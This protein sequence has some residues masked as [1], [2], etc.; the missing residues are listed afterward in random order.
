MIVNSAVL[1]DH[2]RKDTIAGLCEGRYLFLV[3]GI[4]LAQRQA[5]SICVKAGK[6]L[7]GLFLFSFVFALRSFPS[8]P[9][10]N[11]T[12]RPILFFFLFSL[13]FQSSLTLLSLPFLF[14][15]S[16]RIS[17]VFNFLCSNV[18][19]PLR[20]TFPVPSCRQRSSRADVSASRIC[21]SA[22]SGIVQ[23]LPP[24]ATGAAVGVF[25]YSFFCFSLSVAL[26]WATIAHREWKSCECYHVCLC[27]LSHLSLDI[28]LTQCHATR[29]GDACVL[30]GAGNLG[31]YGSTA[32]HISEVD[33]HQVGP[34][35]LH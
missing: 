6:T 35:R 3:F 23:E 22:M 13:A 34:V 8:C 4:S 21:L 26:L 31:F 5:Y 32:S 25:L 29:R 15:F 19:Y 2:S 9:S 16:L 20:P 30:Y 33:E 27:D 14:I 28:I 1:P 18:E 10:A 17:W 7:A 24:E 12:G 11:L